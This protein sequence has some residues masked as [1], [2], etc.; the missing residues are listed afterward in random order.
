MTNIPLILLTLPSMFK[1]SYILSDIKEWLRG[2]PA[3]TMTTFLDME[4]NIQGSSVSDRESMRLE[5]ILTR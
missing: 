3:E 2:P 4:H 5:T 1:E